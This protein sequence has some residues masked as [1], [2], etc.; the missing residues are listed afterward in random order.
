MSVMRVFPFITLHGHEAL[1]QYPLSSPPSVMIMRWIF[2]PIRRWRV[3]STEPR[4]F[5][6][7]LYV[8]KGI[9]R[10]AFVRKVLSRVKGDTIRI[11]CAK[12]PIPCSPLAPEAKI[13]KS[14]SFT[15]VIREVVWFPT[16]SSAFIERDASMS[17]KIFSWFSPSHGGWDQRRNN[18]M[19][20]RLRREMTK[21]ILFR[22][23]WWVHVEIFGSRIFMCVLYRFF[24]WCNRFALFSFSILSSYETVPPLSH[25]TVPEIPLT[26][27]QYLGKIARSSAVLSIYSFV[28]WV[29][30]GVDRET[31]SDSVKSEG[32]LAGHAV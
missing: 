29:C 10:T 4:I 23:I 15:I 21:R 28:F 6:P 11:S 1:R 7:P 14:E 32:T 12:R 18:G 22:E 8:M 26:W 25:I 17:Q 16:F 13:R 31:M 24:P 27:P 19:S 5:V 20:A 30:E 9:F 3:S 2:S